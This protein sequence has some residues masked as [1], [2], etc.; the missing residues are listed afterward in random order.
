MAATRDLVVQVTADVTGLNSG[1]AK[2]AQSLA[3]MEKQA[4]D[5]ERQIKK[6]G[7][8]GANFQKLV[9]DFAGVTQAQT[10]AARASADAFQEFSKLQDAV[11]DLR[12][13]ID[14]AY[15][16]TKRYE[17]ALGTLDDALARGVISADDHAASVKALDDGMT[18]ATK[19]AGGF[20]N[21]A[22]GVAQQLSQVG[23]QTMAT[24]NF[25]Q[26]LA[27]QLPDIGIGF[28]AIGA[29]A[30]LVAGVAL[31][32][33]ISA[34]GSTADAAKKVE[35]ATNASEKAMSELQSA[36][37]AATQPMA[38]LAEKY[39]LAANEA[40]RFLSAIADA[41]ALDAMDAVQAEVAA[42]SESLGLLYATSAAQKSGFATGLASDLGLVR[43]TAQEV[44][45][46]IDSMARA[47]GMDEQ[48]AAARRL[49]DTL[50]RVYGSIEKMPKPMR[51]LA[52]ATAG[53][54][55]KSLQLRNPLER[56]ADA[57]ARLVG[58]EPGADFLSMAIDRARALGGALAAAVAAKQKLAS[59]F[60][61]DATAG[62]PGS[63][64]S[65]LPSVA[66]GTMEP[67]VI[68][69][70]SWGGG[71]SGGGGGGKGENPL[72]KLRQ[73]FAT[74]AELEMQAYA[75]EQEQLQAA[76]DGKVISLERYQQLAE[77]MQRDHQ[78]RMSEID[79]WQYGTGV[80]K[81]AS[82]FGDMAQIMEA[83]GDKTLQIAKSFGAAQALVNAWTGASEALKLPFPGNLLAFGKVLAT[84][85]SAVNAIKGAGKGGSSSGAA[86]ASSVSTTAAQAPMQVS[87]TGLNASDLFSGNVISGLLDKLNAEAGDRGYKI[88]GFA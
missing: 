64:T 42:I 50:I 77:Q 43:D 25:V 71:G 47:Q 30:G 66:P 29:A 26:A 5:T 49:Y 82:F 83:G 39:G 32:M 53:A 85:F 70:G 13:S 72:E 6:I 52:T 78:G 40:R 81:A 46:A 36:A 34:M 80:E 35:D 1:M 17:A 45:S 54:V 8:A 41:K 74:K 58:Y 79:V 11:D 28:G 37:Q 9:N 76:L 59:D 69:A 88:V 10:G 55:D 2:G 73:Q 63:G 18:G 24:G 86:G 19:G 21:A 56:A 7:E 75:T 4:R 61:V 68:D 14:P 44:Q 57:M 15:A 22:R 65:L 12:G 48:E 51:D 87:L 20:Q 60:T 33:V 3:T 38:N 23:Q 31:P 67:A 84:G 62:S 27:I 16:A